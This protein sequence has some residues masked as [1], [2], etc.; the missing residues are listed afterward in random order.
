MSIDVKEEEEVGARPPVEEDRAR[1]RKVGE[2]EAGRAGKAG[3][4]QV[5]EAGGETHQEESLWTWR[6]SSSSPSKLEELLEQSKDRVG[7]LEAE[8]EQLKAENAEIKEIKK[9]LEA[10]TEHLKAELKEEKAKQINQKSE[11]EK[12]TKLM[13]E[14]QEKVECP[15][16]LMVPREGPVPCCPVGHIICSP[17]LG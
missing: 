1:K 3:R 17:C 8:T 5:S 9:E 7:A 4:C 10:E 16:C 11:M 15:V 2:Q 14:L 13:A 12:T 6:S